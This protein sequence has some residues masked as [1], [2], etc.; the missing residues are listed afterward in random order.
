V[1]YD[2]H[3]H[4]MWASGTVTGCYVTWQADGNLIVNNCSGAP[5]WASNT[6]CHSDYLLTFQADG[7]LVIYNSANRPV[8]Y[9]ATGH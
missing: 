3:D 1:I 9:S 8:W 5:V 2:Q 7:N 4:P 6:C